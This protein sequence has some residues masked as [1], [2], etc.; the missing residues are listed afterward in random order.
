L[1]N[2]FLKEK[3]LDK[4]YPY[5]KDG[6]KIKFVYLKQPNTFKDTVVSFPNRLPVEFALQ[7]FIDYEKQFEK[8]FLEP[9]KIILDCIGWSTEKTYSLFD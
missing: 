9:I 4:K 8:T 1:Y 6:E 5:I 3:N 2:H 7:E